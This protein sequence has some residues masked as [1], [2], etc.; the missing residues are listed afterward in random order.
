MLAFHLLTS[1]THSQ[2][3]LWKEVN[4][5]N[6]HY[7]NI[8]LQFMTEVMIFHIFKHFRYKINTMNQFHPSQP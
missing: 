4:N 1:E 5:I 2:K 8:Y 3:S 7:I 6:E